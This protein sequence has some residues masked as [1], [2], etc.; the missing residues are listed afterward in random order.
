MKCD[1]K[2]RSMFNEKKWF[3][4][5]LS[6]IT[7]ILTFARLGTWNHH[8]LFGGHLVHNS[9]QEICIMLT[10][11]LTISCPF[12]SPLCGDYLAMDVVN[13]LVPS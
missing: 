1:K 5:V 3:E 7:A 10:I 13:I 12:P 2:T 6:K 9:R 11:M 8:V 4:N